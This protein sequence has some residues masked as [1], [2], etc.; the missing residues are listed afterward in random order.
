M[1]R[2]YT[3]S[4]KKMLKF[5]LPIGIGTTARCYIGKDGNVIKLYKDNSDTRFLL[6]TDNYE[7][8]LVEIGKVSNDTF[9]GPKKL[10]YVDNKLAGYIYEYIKG[11]E[12]A[13]MRKSARLS[14]IFGSFEIV[15]DNIK[16]ISDSH[17]ILRDVHG[18]NILFNG[19]YHVIDLDRGVFEDYDPKTIY[20]RNTSEVFITLIDQI[21]GLKPWHDATYSRVNINKYKYDDVDMNLVNDL[22]NA[23]KDACEDDNPT[24]HK[25]RRLTLDRKFINSYEE[26]KYN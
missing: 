24:I 25:I 26:D 5:P 7:E 9:I 12:L 11:H 21:Y 6:K 19:D 3:D 13:H 17:F 15:L 2:V 16:K 8:K 4:I 23:L 22:C 1:E 18:K 14:Q 20:N 10:L